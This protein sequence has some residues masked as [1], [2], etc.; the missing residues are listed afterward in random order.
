LTPYKIIRKQKEKIRMANEMQIFKNDEFGQV[1]IVEINNEPY[2]VGKDVA[3]ALGY[4]KPENAISN[5]VDDED[6]TTTLIQGTG[7]NYR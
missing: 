6:K 4:A 3:E 7:S 5:H 1:R 2:F